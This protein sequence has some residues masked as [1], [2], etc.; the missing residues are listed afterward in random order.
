MKNEDIGFNSKISNE[1]E[2][3]NIDQISQSKNNFNGKENNIF[4]EFDEGLNIS[5]IF[6]GDNYE[7]KSGKN[8]KNNNPFENNSIDKSF[9]EDLDK[10]NITNEDMNESSI[11]N[12]QLDLNNQNTNT[13]K[14]NNDDNKQKSKKKITKDDLNNTPIPLFDCF[15]CACEK[16]GFKY[17]INEILYDKY[18]LY[19]TSIYDINDLDKLICK[20]TL[21][22]DE[23]SEK[24]L[25]LVIKNT[26][27]IKIYI[28]KE[29][30]INYFKSNIYK[31]LCKKKEI[32][33]HRLFK[34]KIE[35]S[36]VRKKK[37]FYFKGINKIPRNSMNNKCLFNSTNSL[38]NNYN[39]LSGLVEPVP[40]INVNNNNIKNNYTI[41][42][43][44][45]NSINFNSLSL[46][47]NEFN[48]YCKD[49]N[50]M[51]DY[52]VEKIEKNDESVNYADDKEEILDFFKFDLSRK[53]TKKDIK[54]E[55]K[56]YN[57]WNPDISS[58]FD[59]N[60]NDDIEYNIRSKNSNIN[61][62]N[63]NKSINIINNKYL[64]KN[65]NINK[66]M[67]FIKYNIAKKNNLIFTFNKNKEKKLNK[68]KNNEINK[69]KDKDKDKIN[70]KNIDKNKINNSV[71]NSKRNNSKVKNKFYQNNV[72]KS[73]T[74]ININKSHDLNKFSNKFIN[75]YYNYNNISNSNYNNNH[76]KKFLSG[77]SYMKSFGSTANSSYNINKSANFVGKS[78]QKLKYNIK[79]ENNN[80]TKSLQYISSS[81]NN[82]S[83]NYSIGV[84]INLKANSSIKSNGIIHCWNPDKISYFHINEKKD[85]NNLNNKKKTNQ[86]MNKNKQLVN[87]FN[88][89]N[90]LNLNLN[91]S[92]AK[93]NYNIKKAKTS[94][95]LGKKKYK[96]QNKKN[97]YS[98]Y[99]KNNNGVFNF[100]IDKEKGNK[101]ITRTNNLLYSSNSIF[102]NINNRDGLYTKSLGL[103]F[104]SNDNNISENNMTNVV[105]NSISN[106]NKSNSN[107]NN[108]INNNNYSK[109]SSPHK[110]NKT[111]YYYNKNNREAKNKINNLIA[112]INNKT[113]NNNSHELYYFNK[114]NNISNFKNKFINCFN[115]T[116]YLER[117]KP[118]KPKNIYT[119]KSNYS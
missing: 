73:I 71:K 67:G 16:I 1:D 79:K 12:I 88:N 107:L 44:S 13:N 119:N 10:I 112:L 49:N 38:I 57:I 51:L 40:Q 64:I 7:I 25:N 42:T 117:P 114:N 61:D 94:K 118:K 56:Y 82:S 74:N 46:N 104:G 102:N 101:I 31:N 30:S 20:K 111:S 81:K 86:N 76:H 89:L 17:Y 66:S 14:N 29:K 95:S 18:L 55:N 43:C 72:N 36:L 48:C 15:F 2:N 45:N 37:D 90:F 80:N 97:N 54:W 22:K 47:N 93:S 5:D 115:S 98:I 11:Q 68:S 99:K 92:R 91:H 63:R 87:I 21:I 52:I 50:N 32:D 78:R 6:G 70:N 41:A 105:F 69:D 116:S 58:D 26:E 4:N 77:L 35:N 34:Q 84:S 75:N 19:E 65:K 9:G 27:Y 53:I 60:D 62:D 33:N 103:S 109:N 106:F 23:K 110:F 113:T 96:N 28:P 8:T 85:N 39:A 83:T 24:L 3:L 100:S 59:E 108:S